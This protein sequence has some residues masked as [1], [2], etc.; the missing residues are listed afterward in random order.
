MNQRSLR[1]GVVLHITGLNLRCSTKGMKV[2]FSWRERGLSFCCGGLLLVVIKLPINCVKNL[3]ALL[4]VKTQ[5]GLLSIVRCHADK[6]VLLGQAS[7]L[8][9]CT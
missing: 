8:A 1:S 4:A 7:Y 2:L 9:A 5:Q 6:A 3:D